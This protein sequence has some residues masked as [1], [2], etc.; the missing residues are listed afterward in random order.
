MM[1]YL[2]IAHAI[3]GRTRLRYPPLRDDAAAATRIADALAAVSG[4]REVKVRPYTGSVLVLHD[5]AVTTEALVAAARAAVPAQRVLQ[6]DEAPP[7]E[8]PTPS[9][10]RIA[11]LA[12]TIAREIDRDLLRRT[13]GRLDLGTLA[14]L[15][16]FGAGALELAVERTV[17]TPPWFNL[18]WWGYRTFTTSEKDEIE[19]NSD[20]E[21]RSDS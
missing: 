12:A 16:F 11:K 15:G 8:G 7:Q 1:R 21:D 17:E 10:S 20:D 2:Q 13:G 19:S 3:P 6:A 18:A 14:T 9:L 4:V 5:P